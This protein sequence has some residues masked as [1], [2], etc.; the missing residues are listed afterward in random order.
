MMERVVISMA[1][2]TSRLFVTPWL[3]ARAAIL[4]TAKMFI[5]THINE[6]VHFDP[7]NNKS[8]VI[9][10]GSY[11]MYNS[12]I[13][14]KLSDSEMS[15]GYYYIRSWDGLNHMKR[16]YFMSS[17][18]LQEA[19]GLKKLS[20]WW[21]LHDYGIQIL[22]NGW[23]AF[24]RRD[25]RSIFAIYDS[26]GVDHSHNV[27]PFMESLEVKGNITAHALTML[28]KHIACIDPHT[29]RYINKVVNFDL[30]ERELKGGD[31]IAEVM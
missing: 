12:Y 10:S 20:T 15:K 4:H 19:L 25:C 13:V 17:A 3:K 6:V 11:W 29:E 31:F 1:S 16:E 5:P 26:D 27:A 23:F 14:A 24:H 22:L 18:N 30:E 21:A 28:L 7:S 9:H 2:W 8:T